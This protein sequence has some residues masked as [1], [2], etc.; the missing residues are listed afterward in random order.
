MT[1]P[2]IANIDGKEKQTKATK[3]KVTVTAFPNATSR[4]IAESNPDR[5][6]FFIWNNSSNSCYI[7]FATTAVSSSPIAII[8][9]WQYFRMVEGTIW[10]GEIAAV[11]NAGT[12]NIVVTELL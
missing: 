11:R 4:L 8:P 12:G 6:G 5:K 7:A 2:L 1:S 3:T 9:A 10:L